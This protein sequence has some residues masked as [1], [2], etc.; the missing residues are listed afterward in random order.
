MVDLS[1][2]RRE[3]PSVSFFFA[4][5]GVFLTKSDGKH[6]RV[7]LFLPHDYAAFRPVLLDF[8]PLICHS[9]ISYCVEMG[10]REIE[11]RVGESESSSSYS[12]YSVFEITPTK[13]SSSLRSSVPSKL[14]KSSTPSHT[15]SSLR[16]SSSS[17]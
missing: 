11:A 10:D 7:G 5:L 15:H 13:P 12:S 14:P 17:S 3:C 8:Y 4:R 1:L 9:L 2:V 16:A 6:P